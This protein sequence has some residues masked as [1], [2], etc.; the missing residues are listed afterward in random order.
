MV[1]PLTMKNLDSLWEYIFCSA[2]KH[3]VH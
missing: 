2:C 3:F 1:R